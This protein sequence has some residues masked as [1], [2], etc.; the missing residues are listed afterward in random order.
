MKATA[1]GEERLTRAPPVAST[2]QAMR[3]FAAVL[4]GLV[5]ALRK[6]YPPILIERRC[7]ECNKLLTRAEAEAC[8]QIKCPRCAHMNDFP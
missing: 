6:V 5:R 2:Y 1:D 4:A 8:I 7:S 3:S